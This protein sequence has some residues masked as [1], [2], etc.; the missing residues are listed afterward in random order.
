MDVIEAEVTVISLR[1]QR[2]DIRKQLAAATQERAC[3]PRSDKR[4]A[5]ALMQKIQSLS[6]QIT[7]LRPEILHYEQ[8]F[9]RKEQHGLWETAVLKLWGA[10]GLAACRAQIRQEKINRKEGLA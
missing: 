3:L 7:R 10:D 8:I 1:A 9:H 6:A 4:G 5:H 2:D